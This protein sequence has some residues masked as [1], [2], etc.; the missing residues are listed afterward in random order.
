M[1]SSQWEAVVDAR[2]GD[3]AIAASL[4]CWREKIFRKINKNKSKKGP[5]QNKVNEIWG[6]F[7]N[8]HRLISE[9]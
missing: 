5:F 6:L 2:E 7:K 9:R 8:R 1:S 4:A 3:G